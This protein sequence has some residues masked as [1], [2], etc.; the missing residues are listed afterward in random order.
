MVSL[1]VNHEILPAKLQHYVVRGV[2]LNW[3]KS[4]LED[5]TQFTEVNNTS[6]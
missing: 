6:F 3:F 2:P 4:Y 1:L 5:R